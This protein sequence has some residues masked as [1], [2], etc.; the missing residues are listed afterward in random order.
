MSKTINIELNQKS[1][2]NAI[3]QLQEYKADLHRKCYEFVDELGKAGIHMARTATS[4]EWRGYI[5]FRN[6]TESTGSGAHGVVLAYNSAEKSVW[7]WKNGEKHYVSVSP[8]L[9]AEF[10]SGNF[11]IEG[12]QG[13]FPDQTHAFDSEWHWTDGTGTHTSS[14][15]YPDQPM[16]MAA[17][18]MI[19]QIESIAR[20]VFSS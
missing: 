15:E 4:D 14:G 6:D 8:I 9:M 19:N 2:A 17:V 20:K 3:K 11:A 16:H 13:T 18:E 12:M 1:I 5:L 10:G 7:W